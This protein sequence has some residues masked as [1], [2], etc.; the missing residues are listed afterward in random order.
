MS[1]RA[2]TL[3]GTL[4]VKD[5]RAPFG[6]SSGVVFFNY[7]DVAK[8]VNAESILAGGHDLE[9]WLFEYHDCP[10]VDNIISST[11]DKS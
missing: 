2:Q 5:S 8:M 11:G 1:A 9:E 3:N 6:W 4:G 10:Y 7:D